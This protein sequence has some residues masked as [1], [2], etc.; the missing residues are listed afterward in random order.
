MADSRERRN[1]PCQ[2]YLILGCQRIVYQPQKHLAGLP[3]PE[4]LAG[5]VVELLGDG[6]Q[7]LLG[8]D[9][10]VGA[11]REALSQ[12][13]V[14]VLVGAALPWRVRVAEVDVHVQR[15]RYLAVQRH[16]RA[17]VPRQRVSHK[18][19]KP[20]HL[21][22]DGL[23]HLAGAVAVGQVQ[24]DDVPARP[25][26]QRAYGALV[27]CARYEVAFPVARHGAVLHLGRPLGDHRHRLAEARLAR[28][29]GRPR[30]AGRAPAAQLLGDIALELPLRLDVDGLVYGLG[31]CVHALIIGVFRRE[32]MENLLGAPM[33]V[34]LGLDGRREPS[35]LELARLG[36]PA[37][38][39][40]HLAGPVRGVAPGA[41]IAVARHLP[42]NGRPAA[43]EPGGDGRHA[44]AAHR[45][46]GDEYALVHA[47][48]PGARRLRLRHGRLRPLCA[49][50]LV[51]AR[52]ARP[53]VAPRLT[54]SL[55]DAD[56]A[57]GLRVAH[58]REHE[59]DV[60]T[61]LGGQHLAL[62]LVGDSCVFVSHQRPFPR[63]MVLRRSL[64]STP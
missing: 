53:A 40:R 34:E 35:V 48:V 14:R 45:P 51:A 30:P 7:V 31:R 4:R 42:A 57:G 15:H 22:D 54:G 32:P 63:S 9:A 44:Q 17:L 36:P 26:H 39:G 50:G 24:Q 3:S 10:Q 43:P 61:P 18:L 25:L 58:A 8:E 38:G 23:L 5:P 28:V 29:G 20:R 60:V 47:Q 2:Q 52:A 19:G 11:L 37:P 46:V 16:L 1:T 33:D 13:A 55:G 12:Q 62:P 56:G 59:L 64:E 21:P 49:R 41:P 27:R 6:V